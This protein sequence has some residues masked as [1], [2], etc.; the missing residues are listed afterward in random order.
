MGED[1]DAKDFSLMLYDSALVSAGFDIDD[2]QNFQK[3]MLKGILNGLGVDE[4]AKPEEPGTNQM[5]R[6]PRTRRP[7]TRRRRKSYNSDRWEHYQCRITP[8]S[9][10]KKKKKKKKIPGFLPPFKKKKKKKKS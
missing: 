6:R 9:L 5:R 1:D 10:K 3:R 2:Q 4:E 8:A 7:R